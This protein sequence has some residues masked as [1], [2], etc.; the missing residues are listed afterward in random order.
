VGI[1]F[2]QKDNICTLELPTTCASKMLRNFQSPYAATIDQKLADAGMI[3]LAKTN[4]DEFAMGSSNETS[5]YGPTHNPWDQ[6]RVPGGSSGGSAAAI[7]ACL[8]PAATGT[9]TG[10]SIRQP[11][12]FCNLTGLKPSYGRVSRYGVVAFASSLDHPG[13]MARCAEDIA[14]L[15]S[16]M[17]GFDEKDSTSLNQPVPNYQENLNRSL[18]GIKI[19]LPREYFNEHLDPTI[20]ALLEE[21]IKHYEMLGARIQ[22]INLPNSHLLVPTYYIIAS[23]ECS[24]NL[25]RYDGV[26]YGHR[27]ANPVDLT[28]LYKRSRAEGFGEEV[29]RRILM[30]TYVLSAGYQQAYYNKAQQVRALICK[31]FETAFTQVDCIL[32][33]TTPTTAFKLGEKAHDPIAMYLSDVYTIASNLAGLPA[34]SIPAG[35]IDHL[36]IGMQIIGRYFAEEQLLNLAHR[37]QQVTD[38]HKQIP[39][40]F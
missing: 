21:A 40:G 4:M 18:S 2:A 22:K 28:D 31:D 25:A 6:T 37:Y 36:P 17:A 14:L 29:K 15:M 5:C 12:A 16:A 13:P 24:S 19:G 3:L 30:G 10:R 39:K 27:C 26:R 35:F 11:A 1:P 8:V 32:G 9:D 38:W 7:A 33:P 20:A 34:I 23:A